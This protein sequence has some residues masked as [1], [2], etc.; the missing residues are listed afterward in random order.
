MLRENE[1]FGFVVKGCNPAFIES[2]DEFGPADRAG[3][4]PGDFIVKLN[5]L[6]VR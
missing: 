6:D 3:L 4:C 1:S 2:V 5:G